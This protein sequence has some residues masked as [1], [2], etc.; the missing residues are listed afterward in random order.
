MKE[1]M[2]KFHVPKE[3]DF[4]K[5]VRTYSLNGKVVQL[6]TSYFDRRIVPFLSEEIAKK[7]IYEYLEKELKLKISYSQRE[8][9]FRKSTEEEKSYINLENID[10]VVV[11]DTHAYLSNGNLFQYETITYH[12]DEF[13]FTAIA[14]R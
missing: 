4:Y 10:R 13:T 5:V 12:P 7:S 2:E 3:A 11:I 6:A 14:K 9:K 1:L 8:I